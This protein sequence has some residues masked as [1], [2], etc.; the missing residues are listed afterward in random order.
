MKHQTAQASRP[1]RL[2][3][4]MGNP[5]AQNFTSSDRTAGHGDYY[6][7]RNDTACLPQFNAGG[8]DPEVRPVVLKWS[9]QERIDA[10]INFARKPG[11]LAFRDAGHAH[12]FD[13]FFDRTL[14]RL[15]CRLSE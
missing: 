9:I 3:H 11:H 14:K 4:G 10:L 5:H 12:G 2:S 7:D 8:V 13:Q 15:R 6:R 1:E